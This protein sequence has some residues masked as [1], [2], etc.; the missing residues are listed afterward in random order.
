DLVRP[1]LQ[2]MAKLI[3]LTGQRASLVNQFAK[4]VPRHIGTARAELLTN[5][6]QV[7]AKCAK[8]IHR[9]EFPLK[10]LES[11]I[12]VGLSQLTGPYLTSCYLGIFGPLTCVA[13]LQTISL[14]SW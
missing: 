6:L 10:R 2:F 11:S 1:C 4:L 14:C 9:S 12:E 8:V 5:G 3:D 13:R 7:I